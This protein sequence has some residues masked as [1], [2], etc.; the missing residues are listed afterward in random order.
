MSKRKTCNCMEW[1]R[2]EESMIQDL[3]KAPLII[4]G[5]PTDQFPVRIEAIRMLRRLE[6]ADKFIPTDDPCQE[7]H[8]LPIV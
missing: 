2:Q 3:M 4:D 1:S 7:C 8:E 6:R 5:K